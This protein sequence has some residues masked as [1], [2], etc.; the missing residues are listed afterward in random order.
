MTVKKVGRNDPCPC[1]SGK[2]YKRCCL[3]KDQAAN[4]T[5][6]AP[7]QPAADEP[8]DD[9][10]DPVITAEDVVSLIEHELE[11]GNV[12]YQMI[13]RY[14]ANRM[15]GEYEWDHI[16]MAVTMLNLY[17]GTAQPVLRTAGVIAG[18]MEYFTAQAFGIEGVTLTSLA[19][20]YDVSASAISRRYKDLEAFAEALY[21]QENAAPGQPRAVGMPPNLKQL[22]DSPEALEQLA[23]ESD[24]PAELAQI[25][26]YYTWDE[27]SPTKRI[28]L[29][30]QAL[31]I[32]PDSADAWNI[33]AEESSSPEEA[34][35]YY[36]KGMEAGKKHLGRKFFRENRGL[37][38]GI[39]KTRPFMRA[40][41][42][43]AHTLHK[44]G[45]H[46][47]AIREYKELLEL[48]PND[49][50][51]ARYLLVLAYLELKEYGAADK[52]MNQTYAD[53]ISAEFNYNRLLTE[54]GM[55]GITPALNRLFR[56]AVHYNPHIPEFLTGK[57]RLP[58]KMPE[59][60]VVGD[61]TEA[62]AYA[63]DHL[64]LWRER[65][66]LLAWVDDRLQSR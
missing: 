17:T 4:V 23:R 64:H 53:D 42:G 54:Y 38:W 62:A 21:E 13:A 15:A 5:R 61:T 9:F 25:L 55:R 52:L 60:I 16:A 39:L 27:P 44:S 47:E 63:G 8:E 46:R 57:K 3:E 66:E 45:R 56:Q 32:Y 51:G 41:F 26:L 28:D 2:K 65:P 33:L 24:D 40:K 48:N 29:A 49:N 18:A 11:W 37:F 50:Q 35:E 58:R 36:R 30:R 22:A 34:L 19:E 7:G 43:F 1:G 10:S 31:R 59:R 12:L 20:K 14:L 6:I